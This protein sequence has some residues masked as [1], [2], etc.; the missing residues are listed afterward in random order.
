MS[1]GINQMR[2]A[3]LCNEYPGHEKH[4]ISSRLSAALETG[5]N[6][7][8]LSQDDR[9]LLSVWLD[10]TDL[11]GTPMTGHQPFGMSRCEITRGEPQDCSL[12]AFQRLS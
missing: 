8:D 2:S 6:S 9:Q 12:V 4:V 7:A 10:H 3:A 11:M 1:G 5:P